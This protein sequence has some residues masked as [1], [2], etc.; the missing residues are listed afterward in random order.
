MA[1]AAGLSAK[2]GMLSTG[3]DVEASVAWEFLESKGNSRLT[4]GWS[5]DAITTSTRGGFGI[6]KDLVK[7]PGLEIDLGAYVTQEYE[8]LLRGELD[9]RLGVGLSVS[10]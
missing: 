1:R 9:P 5:L 2:T 3:G 10:F 7:R 6:A 4:S 8:G